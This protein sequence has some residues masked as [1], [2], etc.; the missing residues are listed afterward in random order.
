MTQS[1]LIALASLLTSS[2]T[3]LCAIYRAFL[4]LKHT[5]RP[6]IAVVMLSPLS[7]VLAC[8]SDVTFIFEIYNV[9]YWYGA[10][11]ALDIIVFC[12]FNPS[13]ELAELRYG[14]VQELSNTHVRLGKGGQKFI[15]ATGIK[16]P[17]KGDAEKIHV[18]TTTP[19]TPGNYRIKI[20]AYSSS[21][22]SAAKNYLVSCA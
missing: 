16:L 4:A 13:F 5:A 22:I 20:S 8:S 12:N 18:S 3:A 15:R 11:P 10:T 21:G 17:S 2:V 7:E 14:S 1:D 9:G 19:A 6:R